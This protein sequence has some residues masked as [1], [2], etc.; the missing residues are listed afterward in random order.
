V[1]GAY[2][3][4]NQVAFDLNGNPIT[5]NGPFFNSQNV[6]T[7]PANGTEYDGSTDLL[8][9]LATA[10]PGVHTLT[11]VICD[12]GDRVFDS[13][14][15]ITGLNGCVGNDCSGTLPCDL[16]DN[17]GDGA[18]S[19]DDC[20]DA[21][22]ATHPGASE[23]CNEVDDN[24]DG[25]VDEGNVC[26]PDED[27]DGICD[28]NDN[29]VSVPNANQVDIDFDGLG[30][31]CDNC[32]QVTNPDQA[33][34]DGDGF[35][36]VCDNCPATASADQSDGDNDGVGD[37]CDNCATVPNAD[38]ANSDGDA[39]GDVCEPG[40]LT[41]QRG[42]LGNVYDSDLGAGNGSWAA[43]DYPYMWTGFSPEVHR[44]LIKF[45]LSVVP[46]YA[47]V[48]S[49]TVAVYEHWNEDFSEIRAHAVLAPW[50]EPTVSYPNFGSDA[51]FSPDVAGSFFG[52]GFGT[53]SFDLTAL[54]AAWL[55]GSV[56]NEGILL[57]QDLVGSGTGLHAFSASESSS[58]SSRPSLTVCYGF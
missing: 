30:D 5:I 2:L 47:V 49:A 46:Q 19:C 17:D 38:Q 34:A 18:N 13:G 20:D 9:T 55:D 25:Q 31:A 52:G 27:G 39:E 16:I 43:G 22:P 28:F 10:A 3:D 36:D 23:T 4:G 35:G 45:D 56:A 26:C 58:V 32:T 37:V 57:E 51:N 6:V 14:V 11:L 12:A 40:C 8:T 33:D 53:K 29:C 42:V 41:I 44:A 1:Y 50:D 15:F 24:C 7:P 54:T 21:N 48:S